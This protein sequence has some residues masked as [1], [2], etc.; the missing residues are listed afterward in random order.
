MGRCKS[1]CKFVSFFKRKKG[2]NSSGYENR[3]VYIIIKVKGVEGVVMK[4]FERRYVN[5][6]AS[7]P[8]CNI[9]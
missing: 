6:I 5:K 3:C 1:G 4:L 8:E 9:L 7:G 2:L